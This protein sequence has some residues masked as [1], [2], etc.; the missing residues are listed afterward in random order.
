M[1]RDKKGQKRYSW[2]VIQKYKIFDSVNISFGLTLFRRFDLNVFKCP[3]VASRTWSEPTCGTTQWLG[4]IQSERGHSCFHR[5]VLL[6]AFYTIPHIFQCPWHT[7]AFIGIQSLIL[8]NEFWMLSYRLMFTHHCTWVFSVTMPC[9]PKCSNIFLAPWYDPTAH[10]Y[11]PSCSWTSV[12][13]L[14]SC[15]GWMM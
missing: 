9:V 4:M 3:L 5:P 14:T 10:I 13:S 12:R 1:Y 7:S 2:K 8:H 6:F 11:S 15:Q